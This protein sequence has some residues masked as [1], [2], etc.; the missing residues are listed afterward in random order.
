LNLLRKK[1]RSKKEKSP[2]YW[3]SL[4]EPLVEKAHNLSKLF[5]LKSRRNYKKGNKDILWEKPK[6]D[7]GEET[8]VETLA[9][10]ELE[11]GVDEVGRGSLAGP[12]TAAAVILDPSLKIEGLKDSKALSAKKRESLEE[13]IKEKSICWSVVSVDRK[14]IDSINIKQASLV[15]MKK[16]TLKLE[17]APQKILFDGEDI[18]KTEIPSLAI[19]DGDKKHENI[20]AA[21]IIAKVTRDRLMV[22]L[23]QQYPKYRFKQNKGYG[24]ELHILALKLYG[25]CEEHRRTF[26]PVRQVV[27]NL[28]KTSQ[29]RKIRR[30]V[31]DYLSTKT[32]DQI[33]TA[34]KEWKREISADSYSEIRRL[35]REEWAF[36]KAAS[37][38]RNF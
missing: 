31:R 5:K 22:D 24:S 29:K 27:E 26:K 10:K 23:D 4:G 25:P 14:T 13:E 16:A 36:I 34:L 11:A 38:L 3:E 33:N 30:L 28:E 20:M 7:P 12:V 19:I 8:V 6:F 2:K 35:L 37:K 21:S 17:I 15:A 9:I 1:V 32:D 18:P